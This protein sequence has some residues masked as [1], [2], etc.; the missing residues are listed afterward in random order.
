MIEVIVNTTEYGQP[1]DDVIE[2]SVCGM[3][4]REIETNPYF[5]FK[6]NH[7]SI[8]RFKTEEEFNKWFKEYY[9]DLL[10]YEH[11]I[12]IDEE[13][14]TEYVSWERSCDLNL[15]IVLKVERR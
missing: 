15:E 3:S 13:G 14:K 11:W 5:Q 10:D 2:A 1:Y 7:C 9:L 4:E 8:I 12:D 6:S